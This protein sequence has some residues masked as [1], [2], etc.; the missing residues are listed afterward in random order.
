MLLPRAQNSL[1]FVGQGFSLALSRLK[2]LPYKNDIFDVN[3][4]MLRLIIT[5]KGWRIEK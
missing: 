2:G 1:H 4:I 5:E 3:N